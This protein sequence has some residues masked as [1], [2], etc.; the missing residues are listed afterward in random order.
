MQLRAFCKR[1]RRTSVAIRRTLLIMKLTTFILLLLCLHASAKTH[2]QEITLSLNNVNLETVFKEIQRQT[3]YK[4]V[5]TKEQLEGSSKV[6]I[7]VK[8]EL[9]EAVLQLCFK[10]QPLT[11]TLSERHIIIRIKEKPVESTTILQ[12]PDIAGRV[13][14]EQG[15]P[16]NGATITVKG[17]NK[18]TATNDKGE[19]VLQDVL[20]NAILIISNV[21]FQLQEIRLQ[22]K[23]FVSVQLKLVVNSLDETIVIA[24]GT[25]TKRLNTG[26]VSKV[27]AED[28]SKQPVS[29]PLAA[30]QGRVPGLII[31]QGNGLPGSGFSVLIRG[32]NSIQN[33][34]SPLFIIDGIPFLSSD[35]R[36]TQRS[37]IN[38]NTPLNTLNPEDILS[39]EILK[40]ADA[41]AIYGSRGANGVILIT[42][43]RP[44]ANESLVEVN[45]YHGWG[46]STRTM[47]FLNTA[48]YLQMRREAFINDGVVPDASNAPDL[49]LWDT[50]RNT[51]W[52]KV[53]MGETAKTFNA[54]LRYSGGNDV[55]GFTLGANYNSETTVF[56]GDFGNR[57]ANVSLS[58]SHRPKKVKL[59]SEF[60]TS[61]STQYS[62]LPLQNVGQFLTLPPHAMNLYDS[63]GNINWTEGG[64]YFGNPLAIFR[65]TYTGITQRFSGNAVLRYKFN[66]RL[67]LNVTGG[68]NSIWFDE[69]SL[70]PLASQNP[71]LNPFG[72]TS[73]G[74]TTIQNWAIEPQLDYT[75]KL[76]SK[77]KL[78]ILVGAS[79]QESQTKKSLTS[80]AGYTN[81]ALIESIGGA[82]STIS[83]N[84]K[85]QYRYHA[86]FSRINYNW[87]NRYLLNITARRD[88]SSRFGPDKRNANFAAVGTGWIFTNPKNLNKNSFLSYGKVR[89]S[90]GITGNDQISNYQYLDTWVGTRY[91][92]QGIPGY[93]P[94]KLF[95][96]D[97]SWEQIRKIE[98]AVELGVLKNRIL[99]NLNWFNN[100]SNN[101]IINYKLP[102]QTGFNQIL[103]NFPGI[104]ENEGVEIQV[105]SFNIKT[106]NFE[107]S[108]SF[109]ITFSKNKLI[110]FPGLESSSYAANYLIGKPLNSF[111]GYH[112]LGIDPQTGLYTFEDVNNNGQMDFDASDYVYNGTTDPLFYGG[113]Q[114][115]FK[116]KN[117]EFDFL[118][119]FKKQSGIDNVKNSS[120]LIGSITNLP[121]QVLKRWQKQG[122]NAE[123]QKFSQDF[124]SPAY[125]T[126]YL[127]S[128]SDAILADASFIRLKNMSLSYNLSSARLQKIGV[129]KCR[130]YMQ[131]QNL[132]TITKYPGADPENQSMVALSPMRIIAGGIK[133]SF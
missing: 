116:Y 100:K 12:L 14:N 97:Y 54:N 3:A 19:F 21:G 84:S 92:Y 34:I 124:A 113:F 64:E 58:V 62:K 42:T 17:T 4:F 5:Y 90:Y 57:E 46:S 130:I 69:T 99:F 94:S 123:Y 18:G 10:D 121:V 74:N 106:K 53:L 77:G 60:T 55:T 112:Y 120:I 26:S 132:F 16:L 7:K 82:A 68:Y 72:S 66:Q 128:L 117:F 78:Q 75:D 102:A 87:D 80:G 96:P 98:T 71:S 39:I 91:P 133:F 104:V 47:N 25:T 118:F 101:Q 85:G 126:S 107:W 111:I 20:P 93:R 44:K 52:K 11:Y 89:G 122:D 30:L 109:N 27:S 6:S 115:T 103:R 13:T 15:E 76:G 43:K 83:T 32:R 2:S 33:G 119:E 108:S 24:Y 51:N 31:T 29:N 59:N 70:T 81:D 38:A 40:D 95:N 105:E 131:A 65:Q 41:T 45:V 63:T 110:A 88:G 36:L 8:G 23:L 73:F 9:L 86:I 79:W 125:E 61:Y 48:Q 67:N 114:N 56:P 49:L 35:D 129:S 127:Y 1:L 22:G 28:I 37:G 50:A